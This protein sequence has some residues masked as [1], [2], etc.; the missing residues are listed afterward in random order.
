VDLIEVVGRIH[1]VCENPP[2]LP[3][4]SPYPLGDARE[5]VYWAEG[6]RLYR[7]VSR[8]DR[9]VV[10]AESSLGTLVLTYRFDDLSLDRWRWLF[11]PEGEERNG[12]AQRLKE[13]GAKLVVRLRY[14]IERT[15]H[16]LCRKPSGS[17]AA[18]S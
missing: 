8:I 9:R 16:W 6:E 2:V 7:I 4:A 1:G 17:R 14:D 11:V 12:P 10:S 13:R 3:L 15:L 18:S 5:A